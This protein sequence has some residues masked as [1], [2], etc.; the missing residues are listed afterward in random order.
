MVAREAKKLAGYRARIRNIFTI[1]SLVVCEESLASNATPP[2]PARHCPQCLC[3]IL[4]ICGKFRNNFYQSQSWTSNHDP[5]MAWYESYV[6]I[7]YIRRWKYIYKYTM[8]AIS[9]NAI[10]LCKKIFKYLISTLL[11]FIKRKN[12][13]EWNLEHLLFNFTPNRIGLKV[14]VQVFET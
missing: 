7:Y 9:C 13:Q 10:S 6:Q 11:L 3:E 12:V 2:W 8:V 5:L 4:N 14:S 1:V